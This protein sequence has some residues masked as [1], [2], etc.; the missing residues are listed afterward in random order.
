ML[1]RL[2][3]VNKLRQTHVSA[4]RHDQV[5]ARATIKATRLRWAGCLNLTH[6]NIP[7]MG[8]GVEKFMY[9]AIESLQV[10]KAV[11]GGKAVLRPNAF[12]LH[13]SKETLAVKLAC[14]SVGTYIIEHVTQF[15][16]PPEVVRTRTSSSFWSLMQCWSLWKPIGILPALLPGTVLCIV[17]M[18]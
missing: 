3:R 9:Y 13:N 6:C 14:D 16:M 18:T 12:M 17:R 11:L 15:K 8:R 7:E 10:K 5:R 2:I 4:Y 1:E